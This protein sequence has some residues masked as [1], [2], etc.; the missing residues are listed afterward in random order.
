M[1]WDCATKKHEAYKVAIIKAL[2]FLS[3]KFSIEHLSYLFLKVKSLQMNE[4]DKF[5]LQLIRNIARRI[6]N[7]DNT[8]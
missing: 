3:S 8:E 2:T 4:I 1:I 7:S 5:C 6:S